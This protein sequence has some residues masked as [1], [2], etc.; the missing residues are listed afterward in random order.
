MIVHLSDHWDLCDRTN[1][2]CDRK[3]NITHY[4][5]LL[6]ITNRAILLLIL[7]EGEDYF[8]G[9]DIGIMNRQDVY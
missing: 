1:R 2:V 3:H 8:F 5:I 6:A 4:K 7:A 9:V